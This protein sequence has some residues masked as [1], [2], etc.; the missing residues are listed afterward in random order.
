MVRRKNIHFCDT[1]YTHHNHITDWTEYT[2]FDINPSTKMD[3]LSGSTLL[4]MCYYTP[5]QTTI[6]SHAADTRGHTWGT[7]GVVDT[8]P[9]HPTSEHNA[10]SY[11]WMSLDAY[12]WMAVQ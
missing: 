7:H 10:G 5:R 4:E 11:A 6:R 8:K 9:E 12:Y 3:T 2:P 1:T